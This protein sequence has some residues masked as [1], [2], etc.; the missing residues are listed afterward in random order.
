MTF[1]KAD[2]PNIFFFLMFA[3]WKKHMAYIAAITTKAYIYI[4]KSLR[5]H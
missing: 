1:E 2:F 4:Y 5:H 3:S